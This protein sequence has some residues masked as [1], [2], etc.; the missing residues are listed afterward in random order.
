MIR[1]IITTTIAVLSI[2][3][4]NAI[5]ADDQYMVDSDGDTYPD[6]TEKIG[7]TDPLNPEDFPGKGSGG[8]DKASIGSTATGVV[9]ES[10]GFPRATCRAGFRTIGR[11]CIS[12]TLRPAMRYELASLYCRDRFARVASYEDLFYLYMRSNLDGFYNPNGRWIGNFAGD[13]TIFRGNRNITFNND[14]DIWN[15]EGPANKSNNRRFWCA[16]DNE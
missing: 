2:F 8:S 3:S 6:I 1:N 14:P 16:H 15:F 10:V 4:V 13:D 11:L 9:T 12:Y 5:S 7:G